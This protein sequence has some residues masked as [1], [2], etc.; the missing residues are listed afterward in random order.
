MLSAL[1]LPAPAIG[2]EALYVLQQTS[3]PALIAAPSTLGDERAEARLLSPGALRA[4]AYALFLA[5]A[6]EWAPASDWPADSLIVLDAAGRPVPGAAI[7]LGGALVLETD[8]RGLVRFARTEPGPIEVLVEDPRVRVRS[9]L[10]ESR[11]GAV[12][13]G[14]PGR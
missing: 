9:V 13:T 14:T 2:E 10:L 6:R 1:G 8:T 11:R 7:N 4:E 3:C 5:L 12:L